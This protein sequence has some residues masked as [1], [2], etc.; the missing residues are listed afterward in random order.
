MIAYPG[1]HRNG[2]VEHQFDD[3]SKPAVDPSTYDGIEPVVMDLPA[4]DGVLLNPLCLHAS[5][6][7]RS[8]RT[9][10]TLMVQI[11]DYTTLIDPDD[12]AGEFA[13]LKRFAA[14]RQRVDAAADR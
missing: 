8:A 7:N 6:Q 2:V 4:G 1:T 13:R 14:G 9:K 11:Q 3:T 10:F 12:D 5:V